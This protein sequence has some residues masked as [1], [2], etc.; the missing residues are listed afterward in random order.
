MYLA[1]REEHVV[2]HSNTDVEAGRTANFAALECLGWTDTSS[3]PASLSRIGLV[4]RCPSMR[5]GNA[6][7]PQTLRSRL[8]ASRS[9]G[10]PVPVLGERFDLAW[11]IASAVAN[12]ISVGWSTC[13]LLL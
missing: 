4:F 13:G 5:D 8:S 10:A 12:V 1:G 6:P 11:G 3:M 7:S 9:V 2:Q